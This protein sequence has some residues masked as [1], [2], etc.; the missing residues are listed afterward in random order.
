MYH[1]VE[2]KIRVRVG[3]I[4]IGCGLDHLG[5]ESSPGVRYFSHLQIAELN[6]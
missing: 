5:F 3:G 2:L 4:V 1:C 6:F